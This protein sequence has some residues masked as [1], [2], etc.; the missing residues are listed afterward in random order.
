MS[1]TSAGRAFLGLSVMGLFAVFSGSAAA[2]EAASP[3]PVPTADAK[4]APAPAVAEPERSAGGEV[5][6]SI[7]M[8][9]V[10]IPPGEFEMGSPATE[11]GRDDDEGPTFRVKLTK[12]F[13]LGK[14]EVTQ[15]E[16]EAVMGI[17]PAAF[18]GC[19]KDCPV[20]QVSWDEVQKFLAFLSEKDGVKYRLPTE[21]EWE[22]AA[23]AGTRTP[24]H[25]GALTILGKNDAPELDAIAWYGGNSGVSYEPAEYCSGWPEKRH[26]STACGTHPVGG[27]QPNAWG[28]YDM[29][30]NVW[31]WVADWQAAYTEGPKEDPKG[32]E[33]G[34]ERVSRG[35]AWDV[36][37]R[38]ARSAIRGW[39]PPDTSK[40]AL[41][42]RV[43]RDR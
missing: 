27:K 3:T 8:K 37:A 5:R 26:A 12:G 1:R 24:I 34:T 20:E 35:G 14:Y 31:E 25:A 29:L 23:R 21:A 16:W 41:G 22:Y 40:N 7:G 36:M 2:Q 19:G 39:D 32:P 9:L 38:G 4:K 30:G 6:S 11:V 42:F 43:A 10:W 15:G 33:S 13:Y 18:R 28:L 17:N